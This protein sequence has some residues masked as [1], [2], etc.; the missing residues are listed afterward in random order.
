MTMVKDGQ[1]KE[2]KSRCECGRPV[3]VIVEKDDQKI[4]L[5]KKHAKEYEDHEADATIHGV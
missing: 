2:G 4:G 5:C 1:F 3:H